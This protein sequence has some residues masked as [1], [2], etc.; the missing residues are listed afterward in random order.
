M[1]LI[2]GIILFKIKKKTLDS[3]MSYDLRAFRTKDRCCRPYD[4]GP[5]LG[6]D[7]C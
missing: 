3:V 7:P 6:R 1:Y 2:I 4:L 5:T